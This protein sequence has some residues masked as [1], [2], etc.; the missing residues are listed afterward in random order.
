MDGSWKFSD[1]RLSA[2]NALGEVGHP[3][4]RKTLEA[5]QSEKDILVQQAVEAAL[6]KL[7][8]S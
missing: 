8:S 5:M 4:A 6:A 1:V 3:Q 2:I 7:H